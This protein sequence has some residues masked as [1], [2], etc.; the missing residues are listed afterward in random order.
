MMQPTCIEI[1]N[2][3]DLWLTYVDPDGIT[4]REEFDEGDPDER[5]KTIHELWPLDCNCQ[6]GE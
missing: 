6:D 5:V 1:A 2:N 4:S 3:Y